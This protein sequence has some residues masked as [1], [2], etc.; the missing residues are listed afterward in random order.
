MITLFQA[1][2]MPGSS[3]TLIQGSNGN[4]LHTGDLRAEGHFIDSLIRNP[5]LQRFIA[6][7]RRDFNQFAESRDS[8]EDRNRALYAE[9]IDRKVKV[10]QLDEERSS[11]PQSLSKGPDSS[12]RLKKI[13]LDTE[14]FWAYSRLMSE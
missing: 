9:K 11:S 2:H 14:M 5:A 4:V 1:N 12:L 13:Y 8:R 7:D 6:G 10:K 3:M